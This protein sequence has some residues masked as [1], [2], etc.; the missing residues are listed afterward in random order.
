MER[1][2]KFHWDQADKQF[3]N[4]TINYRFKAS[5]FVIGQLPSSCYTCPSGFC[6][7]P[8]HPCGRNVPFLPEDSI[9]RP[10]TCKLRTLEQYFADKVLENSETE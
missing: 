2:V 3:V 1:T 10:A 5:D 4:I 8:G 6:T 7:I 9:R